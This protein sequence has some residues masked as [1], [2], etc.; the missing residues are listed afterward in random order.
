MGT[1]PRRGAGGPPSSVINWAKPVY[2][3]I[4]DVIYLIK[5]VENFS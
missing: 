1:K 4:Y 5:E 2:Q 3:Y